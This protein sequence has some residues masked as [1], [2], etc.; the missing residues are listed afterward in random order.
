M[1]RST[2]E[3]LIMLSIFY[4]VLI[5][6]LL[7]V[8]GGIVLPVLRMQTNLSPLVIKIM[9]ISWCGLIFLSVVGCD[10]I[11]GYFCTPKHSRG[12]FSFIKDVRR[13]KTIDLSDVAERLRHKEEKAKG[14]K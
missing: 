6:L 4:G 14:P 11:I 3:S 12:S 7:C 1:K 5:F 10:R 2:R 13:Y 9:G 8:L